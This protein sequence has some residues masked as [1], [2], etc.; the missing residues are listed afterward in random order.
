MKR[1]IILL[2]LML[3]IPVGCSMAEPDT[4]NP[5]STPTAHPT[6]Y[7]SETEPTNTS[8]DPTQSTA[9]SNSLLPEE[10]ATL[11][12][13]FSTIDYINQFPTN[14]YAM[15]LM[16]HYDSPSEISLHR[17]FN[18]GLGISIDE[19]ILTEEEVNYLRQYEVFA[20][21]IDT[22][23]TISRIPRESL[24]FIMRQFFGLYPTEYEI[25]VPDMMVYWEKTDCY[26]NI[27]DGYIG[28]IQITIHSAKRQEDGTICFVY[29]FTENDL[30]YSDPIYQ[31]AV[32]LPVYH[33]YHILSNMPYTEVDPE[34]S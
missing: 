7:P 10:I 22:E 2:I 31:V 4:I 21:H 33:G 16:Q 26:Y 3:I 28:S 15:S 30:L 6:A 14:W 34:I 5:T 8:S 24:E 20:T 19:Y 27:Y 23:V 17:L 29:T 18:D 1:F 13:I 11:E 12:Q 32:I 9:D 25:D